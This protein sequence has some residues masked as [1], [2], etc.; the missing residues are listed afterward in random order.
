MS[1]LLFSKITLVI[2]ERFFLKKIKKDINHQFWEKGNKKE[3]KR[4]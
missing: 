3:E 2:F 1:I 4:G